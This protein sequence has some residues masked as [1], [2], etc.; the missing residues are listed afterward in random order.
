MVAE[1]VVSKFDAPHEAE[2]AAGYLREHGMP[3]RVENDVL[4]GMN[5]LWAMALGGIRVFVRQ[6]DAERAQELLSELTQ[7][8]SQALDDPLEA[9]RRSDGSARRA[10]AA[11]VFGI[12]LLP[13]V[14]HVYSLAIVIGIKQADLS[15]RGRRHRLAAIAVDLLALGVFAAVLS[16]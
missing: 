16:R 11:A 5:P 3:A 10:L 12:F 13:V 8:H 9:M 6:I 4:I 7:P 1:V 15:A 14:A 2:L